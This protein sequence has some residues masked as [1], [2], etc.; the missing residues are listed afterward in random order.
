L[1]AGGSAGTA[2]VGGGSGEQFG[3]TKPLLQTQVPVGPQLPCALHVVSEL[4]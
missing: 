4:Q 1:A 2:A 3:P